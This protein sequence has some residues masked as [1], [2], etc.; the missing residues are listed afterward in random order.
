MP[1]APAC[2]DNPCEPEEWGTLCRN[3]VSNLRLEKVRKFICAER[4]GIVSQCV[5][6]VCNSMIAGFST[7][8]L[9]ADCTPRR[10][11]L[12][13]WTAPPRGIRLMCIRSKEMVA[14]STGISMF[15]AGAEPSVAL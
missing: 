11:P 7:A 12:F 4:M 3:A 9:T 5:R 1:C 2:P 10:P 8:F 15:V 6:H 14:H 13:S